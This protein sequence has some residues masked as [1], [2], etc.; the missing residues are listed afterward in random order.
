MVSQS[1][2]ME[3]SFKIFKNI[4]HNFKAVMRNVNNSSQILE[5]TDSQNLFCVTASLRIAAWLTAG[6]ALRHMQSFPKLVKAFLSH[7]ENFLISHDT[8]YDN[9][10]I[11]LPLYHSICII[12]SSSKYLSDT[13]WVRPGDTHEGEQRDICLCSHGG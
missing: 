10:H 9:V 8:L 5:P 1:M 13:N 2:D 7:P 4:F 3:E 11:K 6:W 12:K